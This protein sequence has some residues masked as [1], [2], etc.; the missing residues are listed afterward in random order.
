ME[1]PKWAA[2]KEDKRAPLHLDNSQTVANV[3]VNGKSTLAIV[4]SGSYKTILDVGMA[5]ILGL[6]IREANHGDCG[7]F[8]TPG[9]DRSNC[10]AGVV[11]GNVE[12]QLADDVKYVIQGLKLIHNPHPIVLLGSDVLSG[13]RGPG[14]CNYAGTRL[15][16]K[17]KGGTQ[18]YLCFE[19]DG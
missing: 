1:R 19:R 6:P 11:E 13:G 17:E 4:D 10:Y 8:S 2:D 3:V 7:T 12:L 16:T 18:G 5:R 9:T 15:Q 14:E